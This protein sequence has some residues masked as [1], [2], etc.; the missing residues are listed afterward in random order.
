MIHNKVLTTLFVLLST[1]GLTLQAQESATTKAKSTATEAMSKAESTMDKVSD[2]MPNDAQ[3]TKILH[4][5]N[6]GEIDL[7]KLAKSKSKNDEVKKFADHMIK[8]HT[9]NNKMGKQLTNKLNIKPVTSENSE[10]MKKEGSEKLAELKKLDGKEFDKAYMDSQVNTHTKVLS[11]L[12]NTMLTS[13]KNPELK[14]MLE[15]TRTAVS[16][17]L[18]QAKKIQ[19]TLQ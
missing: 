1:A 3:I 14:A 4:E 10:E 18:D 17:H 8:D 16:Q 11:D 2:S 13:A 12:D 9:S 6:E 15:K 19:S 5:T 7:A